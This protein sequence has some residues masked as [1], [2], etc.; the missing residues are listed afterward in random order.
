MIRGA[1]VLSSH[2]VRHCSVRRSIERWAGWKRE[3]SPPAHCGVSER[4]AQIQSHRARTS[5]A[6]FTVIGCCWWGKVTP[7]PRPPLTSETLRQRASNTISS[8]HVIKRVGEKTECG[9]AAQTTPRNNNIK[10]KDI[11]TR[12]RRYVPFESNLSFKESEFTKQSD[13]R[14]SCDLATSS[15]THFISKPFT[16]QS[17]HETS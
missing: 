12:Q 4:K 10:R 5:F 6:Y 15:Q 11:G 16:L 3:P 17:L 1:P 2:T 14:A 8:F 7:P 9:E 13:D